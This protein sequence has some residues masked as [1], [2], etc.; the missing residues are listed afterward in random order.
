[1][2][3]EE[4]ERAIEFLLKSRAA[5]DA[6]LAASQA[7]FEARHATFAAEQ[8]KT[9]QQI[10]ALS[11]KQDRTQQQLD[12]LSNVVVSIAEVT[13]RNSEELDVLVKTVSGVI[14]RGNGKSER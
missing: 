5:F 2:T 4:M 11:A 8:E 9:T 10:Q 7:A 12:H 14:E 1:M 13:Q 6:S 3:N